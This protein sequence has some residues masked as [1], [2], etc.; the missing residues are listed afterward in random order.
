MSKKKIWKI[1]DG[2]YKKPIDANDIDRLIAEGDV[3]EGDEKKEKKQKTK[4]KTGLISFHNAEDSEDE[5]SDSDEN[6]IIFKKKV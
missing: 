1:L 5:N 6:R 3:A 2:T 4:T